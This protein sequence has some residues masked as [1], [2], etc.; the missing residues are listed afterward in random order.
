MWK[1][2]LYNFLNKFI[3]PLLDL[4]KPT[5]KDI[6][7]AQYKSNQWEYL[8]QIDQL[9]RYSIIVGYFNNLKK[10]GSILD[11][12][13]GEGIFPENL[14]KNFY[15]KYIGID[16]SEVAINQ[17]LIKQ[18]N[19]TFFIKAD[20][21]EFN[22]KQKFDVIIFNEVLYYFE[23]NEILNIMKK[24]KVFLKNDGLFI[25]SMYLSDKT[26]IYLENVGF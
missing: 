8:K 9:A 11:I 18:D 25:V 22:T 24:Y 20:L 5:T 15:S 17:A 12:K 14:C 2:R 3:K 16:I 1:I 7:D 13:C 4:I 6:W 23:A 19:K 26:N 10:G 21:K